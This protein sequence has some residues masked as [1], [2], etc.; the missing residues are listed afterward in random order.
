MI[1]SSCACSCHGHHDLLI[2]AINSYMPLSSSSYDTG[3]CHGFLINVTNNYTPLLFY[4]NDLVVLFIVMVFSLP[5]QIVATITF[6]ILMILWFVVANS[7]PPPPSWFYHLVII[8]AMVIM[9]FLVLINVASNYTPLLSWFWWSCGLVHHHGL[10]ITT[11]NSCHHRPFHLYDLVVLFNIMVFSLLQ[12]VTATIT[13]LILMILWAIH[14]C[15]F[16]IV[17][18]HYPPSPSWSWWSC[19]PIC[20]HGLLV[21]IISKFPP[22]P[23]WSWWSCGPIWYHSLLF[24]IA[25]QFP[26][27]A[28]SPFMILWS[29]P[30]SWSFP[31][32]NQQF[33]VVTLVILMILWSCHCYGLLIATSSSV[34]ITFLILM[35]LWSFSSSWSFYCNNQQMSPSPSSS[36]WSYDLTHQ[37]SLFIA[38]IN[39][40]HHCYFDL[41]DLGF[42]KG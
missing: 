35:V 6:P 14:Y 17:T 36:W 33:L 16:L 8:V 24:V 5:Q 20:C 15:S 25:C 29:Y 41:N 34:T 13:F 30:S 2:V 40:C 28:S 31:C 26:S 3:H 1:L 4:L 12:L 27:L 22:L 9:V 32:Y 7:C 18:N 19:G 39:N 23:S 38:T 11:T 37:R 42:L 21:V 10:L